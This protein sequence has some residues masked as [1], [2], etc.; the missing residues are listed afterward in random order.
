MGADPSR[1]LLGRRKKRWCHVGVVVPVKGAV[2]C[3]LVVL[4]LQ[5]WPSQFRLTRDAW[6]V[7]VKEA[8][9]NR[10]VAG[11]G[12]VLAVVGVVYI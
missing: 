10:G 12:G 5:P 1:R 9:G 3:S 2:P 8:T 6:S 4:P 7:T 11:A